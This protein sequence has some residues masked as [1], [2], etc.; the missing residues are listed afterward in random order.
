MEKKLIRNCPKCGKIFYYKSEVTYKNAIRNNS[1]CRSCSN[2][3]RFSDALELKLL[4]ERIKKW[5]ET[6]ENPFKNKTHREETKKIIAEKSVR[7]GAT[8]GMY[9][10]TLLGIWSDKYG[11]EI[12]LQMWDKHKK[13]LANY[14]EKNGQYGKPPPIKSGN[15]WA[16]WYKGW[17]FRSLLELSYM[18]R[19]IE[20]W[21][22][23]WKSAETDK[24]KIEYEKD[25]RLGTYYADFL[26]NKKYLVECKP[27]SLQD[28]EINRKKFAAARDYCQ[29]HGMVFKVVDIKI[30]SESE[31][32][33]LYI[34]GDIK[35]IDRI[36]E[37]FRKKYM[38]C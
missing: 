30:L 22:I 3:K 26:L 19:V 21:K 8:N 25:D 31:L 4:S 16:G 18:I 37:K 14:G 33:L 13:K 28:T 7:W 29:K 11:K 12:G 2:K 23:E 1:I 17:Y 10:K 6:N 5:H 36:D 38:C 24:L 15:G 35:F 34:S 27:K 32:K 20:R 9:G